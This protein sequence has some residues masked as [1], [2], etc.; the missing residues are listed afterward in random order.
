MSN[1]SIKAFTILEMLVNLAIMSIILGLIYFA[2]STFVDQI[3]LYRE[4]MEQQDKLSGMYLRM[5]TDFYEAV[6]IIKTPEGF[7]A[8]G[9]DESSI[10][11]TVQP[12]QLIR[13]QGM[14]KDTIAI[15]KV[16]LFSETDKNTGEIYIHKAEIRTTMFEE[17]LSLWVAKQYKATTRMNF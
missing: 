8:I 7:S 4:S 14:I 16:V 6:K 9:Y 13:T 10:G 17:S 5:K 2:Y 11:Y 12:Q 3:R 1:Y 15:E